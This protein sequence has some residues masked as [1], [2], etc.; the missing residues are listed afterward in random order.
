MRATISARRFKNRAAGT[1]AVKVEVV[2]A[3]EATAA[4]TP[5]EATRE[6]A[7]ILAAVTPVAVIQVVAVIPVVGAIPATMDKGIADGAMR[8]MKVW[9][10]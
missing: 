8:R 2:T 1:Q 4:D 9:S 3:A 6:E 5:G 7:V 10:N